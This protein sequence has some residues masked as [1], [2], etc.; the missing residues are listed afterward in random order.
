MSARMKL[1]SLGNIRCAPT[2]YFPVV[3]EAKHTGNW[4]LPVGVYILMDRL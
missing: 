3:L 2:L 1:E 4:R